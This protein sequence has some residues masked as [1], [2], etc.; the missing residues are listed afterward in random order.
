MDNCW[1]TDYYRRQDRIYTLGMCNSLFLDL[2]VRQLFSE[3]MIQYFKVNITKKPVIIN[4][5]QFLSGLSASLSHYVSPY[6]FLVYGIVFSSIYKD[7]WEKQ[8]IKVISVLF[9]PPALMYIFFPVYPVFKTPDLVYF[10]RLPKD[11][12]HIVLFLRIQ[13][14]LRIPITKWVKSLMGN[15]HESILIL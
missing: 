14:L 6:T 1:Y 7:K 10:T 11:G 8:R 9:I 4:K 5:L 2:E 12:F 13:V 15:L 3:K